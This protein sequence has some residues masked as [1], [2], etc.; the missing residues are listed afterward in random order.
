LLFNCN[1]S[2]FTLTYGGCYDIAKR[3]I[4]LESK[5]EKIEVSLPTVMLKTVDKGV[6]IECISK[7]LTFDPHSP[8]PP[9]YKN[10]YGVRFCGVCNGRPMFY[11][12]DLFYQVTGSGLNLERFLEFCFTNNLHIDW[13]N[14]QRTSIERGKWPYITLIRKLSYPV[15]EIYGREY[16]EG[17]EKRLMNYEKHLLSL[18]TS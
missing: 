2:N 15:T 8:L 13:Y 4:N 9:R 18:K 16:W 7:V 10:F 14:F 3:T 11:G 5:N 6:P 1:K 12:F 17:L